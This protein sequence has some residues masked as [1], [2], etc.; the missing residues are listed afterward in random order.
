MNDADSALT[1]AR[2]DYDNARQSETAGLADAQA[3]LD[4]A[5]ADLNGLLN[6]SA[7][8]LAGA[9]AALAS[10]EARLAQLTGDQHAGAVPAWVA[11]ARRH[12]LASG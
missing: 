9:R 11:D 2:V 10:A 1:Q 6:P 4:S 3:K 7:E 12:S 8:N 5:Q